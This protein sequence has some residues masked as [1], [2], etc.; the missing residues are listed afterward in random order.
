M[1][2][3]TTIDETSAP[4]VIR[5]LNKCGAA[6]ETAGLR[7]KALSA[8]QLIERAKRRAQLEDFGGPDFFEP[9]SRLL[10][11]CHLEG[12]LNVIGKLA[13]KNDVVR[14]L[15]NRLFLERDR[16]C[17]PDIGQQQIREP[18]FIVGLPRS[19]TTLLHTLLSAVRHKRRYVG[20]IG[21]Q[22]LEFVQGDFA[23]TAAPTVRQ[24]GSVAF[25][26]IDC[27]IR[28]AVQCAYD[29][30][31]PYMI[32]GGYWILDDPMVADCL[33]ATEAME[34]LLIRR[35]GLNSEQ[36]FPHYVFRQP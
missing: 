9:L 20:E 7:S 36:V 35:D 6:L 27:D 18:L 15:C 33:G 2:S 11:S 26:H 17:Y 1:A 24:L 14:I 22:N 34:D 32:S 25:A 31:R 30:T 10:E 4:L 28:S 8:A 29:T 5:L 12:R 16:R 13:L 19:G 23:M 3:R 21:L